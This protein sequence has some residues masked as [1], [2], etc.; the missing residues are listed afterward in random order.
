MFDKQGDIGLLLQTDCV[1]QS[2]ET[3][4]L[5]ALIRKYL[6]HNNEE[7]SNLHSEPTL[8]QL[9]VALLLQLTTHL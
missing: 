5:P 1:N 3:H 4:M 9:H 7:S 2:P 8:S 6:V